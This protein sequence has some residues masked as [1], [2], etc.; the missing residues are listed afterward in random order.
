VEITVR[1]AGIVSKLRGLAVKI[2]REAVQRKLGLHH[3]SNVSKLLSH[4]SIHH[5]GVAE[6][7]SKHASA[8]LDVYRSPDARTG[9][10]YDR[11]LLD[12]EVAVYRPTVGSPRALVSFRGSSNV[13]DALTDG[14]LA[15]GKLHDTDRWKRT[16]EVAQRLKKVFGDYDVTGHSLGGTLAQ[17]VHDVVLDKKGKLVAFNPGATLLG[18]IPGREGRVYS[19]HGDA[20]SALSHE[21]HKDVRV[22]KPSE[23]SDLLGAHGAANF[24]SGRAICFVSDLYTQRHGFDQCN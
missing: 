19:T 10:G 3:V 9:E 24:T 4:L 12:G 23:G 20:V 22:L 2:G 16:A 8:A 5:A 18:P 21:T 11:Q 1:G 13:G 6:E 15:L 7:D 14:S 17:H